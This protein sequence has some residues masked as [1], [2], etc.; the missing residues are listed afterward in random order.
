MDIKFTSDKD[1]EIFNERVTKDMTEYAQ[2][3]RNP[4][5]IEQIVLKTH[6]SCECLLEEIIANSLPNPNAVLSARYS[7]ANKLALVKAIVGVD[8]VK[9]EVTANVETLNK[10]RNQMAR[11]SAS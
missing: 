9:L 8:N 5:E 1:E 7:F 4:N 6:L 3:L 10:L 11:S 2:S